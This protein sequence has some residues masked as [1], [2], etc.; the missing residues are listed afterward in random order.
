MPLSLS[1]EVWYIYDIRREFKSLRFDDHREDEVDQVRKW[2]IPTKSVLSAWRQDLVLE[3]AFGSQ[4][5]CCCW[6]Y[7]WQYI[8]AIYL[9]IYTGNIPGN[10]YE[11]D[12][13]ATP[14][15]CESATTFACRLLVVYNRPKRSSNV[16]GQGNL[17]LASRLV[18]T[19]AVCL[20]C[21][22]PLYSFSLTLILITWWGSQILRHKQGKTPNRNSVWL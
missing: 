7:T 16:Q 13:D 14:I 4:E 6:Q 10:V 8:Q 19:W 18:A 11:T 22:L 17:D 2:D 5:T 15:K 9:T 1:R 20:V 3:K 12:E 21:E